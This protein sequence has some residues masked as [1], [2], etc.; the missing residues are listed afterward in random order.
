MEENHKVEKLLSISE[1]WLQYAIYINLL[2]GKKEN[3]ADL[4]SEALKDKKIQSYLRDISDFHGILVSNHKN[5]ELPIHKLL[6]LLDIGFDAAI[7]EIKN[8]IKQIM[9][10]KDK[11]GVYQSK[12]NIPKHYGGKGEDTFGWCLCD[13]PLMLLALIKAKIDYKTHIKQGVDYLISLYTEQGFP[14]TVSEEHGKFRGPGRKDDCCPYATLI[15]LN[16]LAEIDKYRNS[17]TVKQG[18]EVILSLWENSLH[19]HPYMFYMGTDFRKLKAPSI[20][21]DI[22]SVTDCLS[23]FEIARGDTRLCEMVS[24]IN[25]KQDGDGMFTPESVYQKCKEWDFGQK[26]SVSPYLSY[27][28]IRLLSRLN[29]CLNP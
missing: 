19:R 3:L 22:V 28:C 10:H 14:C 27:L 21:F 29:K 11:F 6:F 23:K 24:I 2:N 7:P 26:K 18:I 20:F 17:D 15:M 25:E 1:P 12:T 9:N 16:L 4:K 8:A 5:P 13:A